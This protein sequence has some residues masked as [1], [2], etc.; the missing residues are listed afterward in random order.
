MG[1]DYELQRAFRNATNSAIPIQSELAKVVS[2]DENECTCVVEL[3][4]DK[5]E[6]TNINL[7]AI[8]D[9]NNEGFILVPE[10]GSHVIVS[11]NANN[12]TEADYFVNMCSVVSSV[13]LSFSGKV[14][15]KITSDGITFFDGEN[16][17]LIKAS[18]LKNQIDKNTKAIKSIINVLTQFVPVASDGGTALKTL[19]NANL[20]AL[21][22]ANLSNIEN[23]KVKH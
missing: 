10:V 14:A 11:L 23:H 6:I 3:V 13:V 16:G 7:R 17:G 8:V 21:S 1:K 9:G 5:A 20:K 15:L 19:A 4:S 2:V 22:L 18:E 12:E